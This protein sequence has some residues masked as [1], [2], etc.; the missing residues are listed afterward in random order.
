MGQVAY[1]IDVLRAL[2]VNDMLP[3]GRRALRV[4]L[5]ASALYLTVPPSSPRACPSSLGRRSTPR[6]L[7]LAPRLLP[8][9]SP[10]LRSLSRYCTVS[11]QLAFAITLTIT[12]GKTTVAACRPMVC[13][14][15]PIRTVIITISSTSSCTFHERHRRRRIVPLWRLCTKFRVSKQ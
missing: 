13:T 15:S 6:L 14:Y 4:R 7:P 12:S 9:E 8:V 1:D 5:R 2:P 10:H 3:T 11:H